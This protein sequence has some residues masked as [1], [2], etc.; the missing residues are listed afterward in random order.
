MTYIVKAYDREMLIVHISGEWE[1]ESA[2]LNELMKD[3]YKP[4]EWWEK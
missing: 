3:G 2:M 4:I 1:S